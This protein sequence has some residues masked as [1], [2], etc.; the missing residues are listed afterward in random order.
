[1]NETRKLLILPKNNYGGRKPG[2]NN[3]MSTTVI[4]KAN[5]N[6]LKPCQDTPGWF[7]PIYE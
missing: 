2:H 3:L 1:M 5:V 4:T 6:G 7:S